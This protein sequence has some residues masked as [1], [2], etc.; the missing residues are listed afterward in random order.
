MIKNMEAV[1]MKGTTSISHPSCGEEK[2]LQ[3]S[4]IKI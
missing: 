1:M 2:T 4:S 3:Q